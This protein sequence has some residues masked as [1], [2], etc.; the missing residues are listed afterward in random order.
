[1]D[2]IPPPAEP[3]TRIAAISACSFSCICWACFIMFCMLPGSFIAL[4]LLQI[5]DGAYFTAEEFSELLYF[6]MRER[7]L[8][9]FVGARRSGC[10]RLG[11][12][13]GRLLHVAK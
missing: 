10:G 4:C 1:M 11:C 9:S 8:R 5:A 3:S 6:G 7:A 2:T 12:R 13:S